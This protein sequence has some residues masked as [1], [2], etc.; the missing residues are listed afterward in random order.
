M[1]GYAVFALCLFVLAL[2]GGGLATAKKSQL[3]EDFGQKLVMVCG[4]LLC[5][6]PCLPEVN[7]SGYQVA[8]LALAIISG[9]LV[10]VY[11]WNERAPTASV[12]SQE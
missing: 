11:C 3:H 5:I 2:L 8:G 9:S 12:F 6:V 7:L 10:G 4:A 1:S